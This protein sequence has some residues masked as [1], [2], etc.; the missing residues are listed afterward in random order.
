[1]AALVAT[2]DWTRPGMRTIG[3]N[4]AILDQGEADSY[5]QWFYDAFNPMTHIQRY[6]RSIAISFQ[7]SRRSCP[8]R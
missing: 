6:E 1:V 7:R 8:S 4:P 5:A 2:P 3:D